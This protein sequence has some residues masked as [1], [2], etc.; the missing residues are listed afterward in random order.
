MKRFILLLFIA[1]LFVS[2]SYAQ[3]QGEAHIGGNL[4]FALST[5][6]S[7]GYMTTGTY[8]NIAPEYGYF[9]TDML[10]VGAEINYEV[11]SKAHS[12]VLSPNITYYYQIINKLYYT[13]QLS[14]GGGVG[15]YSGYVAGIFSSTL[16][17]VSFEYRPTEKWGIA[18]SLICLNYNLIDKTESVNFNAFYSPSVGFRYYF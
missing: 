3:K 10:K 7:N 4:K 2:A 5:S 11:S 1:T 17:L 13:P 15:I 16:N 18:T 8:F 12:V 9:I 14:I 6:G